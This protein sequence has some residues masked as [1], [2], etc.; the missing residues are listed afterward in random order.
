MNKCI[1]VR[2]IYWNDQ[3]QGYAPVN[4]YGQLVLNL[5]GRHR[6]KFTQQ[7]LKDLELL[8]FTVKLED[9]GLYN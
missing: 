3:L 4:N 8:E 1:I 2:K 7:N 9:E 5:L 6:S